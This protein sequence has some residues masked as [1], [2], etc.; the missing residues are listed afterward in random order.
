MRSSGEPM[1]LRSDERAR[2]PAASR[3]GPT[4]TRGARARPC[5]SSRC[6]SPA[7]PS[8]PSLSC[9]HVTPRVFASFTPMR[10]AVDVLVVG[11]R[12]V[13]L[14]EPPR[15]LLAQHAGRLAVR[16]ALDDAAVDVEIAAGERERGRV[17]PERVV[18]LRDQRGRTLA[19]DCVEIVLRRLA[20]VAAS[21]RCASRGRAASRPSGSVA[22]ASRTR[23]ERLVE[24]ARSRRAAPRAARPPRSGSG[25]AS[26]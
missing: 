9:T 22:A 8:Q 2:A 16:V 19:G 14:L 3:A 1:P 5:S 13:A 24:R 21:R 12:E 18:V 4:A 25:R 20:A 10:I 26:R 11:D 17:E 15:G 23:C 7:A 6:Q